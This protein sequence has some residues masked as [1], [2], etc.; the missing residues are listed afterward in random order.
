MKKEEKMNKEIQIKCEGAALVDWKKLKNFQ[1]DLKELTKSGFNKLRSR[2][3]EK[4]FKAPFFVWKDHDYL[5]DGH[6]R[7]RVLE[8]LKKEGFKIPAKL[9]TDYIYAD[10]LEEAKDDL[11]GFISQYGQTTDEGLYQYLHE[12]NLIDSFSVLKD[13]ID[14]PGI[15]LDYFERGFIDNKSFS[16]SISDGI[17]DLRGETRDESL[18]LLLNFEQDSELYEKFRT[19]FEI[20]KTEKA[21]RLQIIKK[22]EKKINGIL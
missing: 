2:I 17:E 5:L 21:V 22:V 4:G 9:P 14:L 6:Q 11:L 19:L 13:S 12:S 7:I 1:G 10:S 16:D 3:V 8:A 18:Y 15:N 20:K